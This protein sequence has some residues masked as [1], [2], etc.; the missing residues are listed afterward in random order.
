MNGGRLE[1]IA[2]DWLMMGRKMRAGKRRKF[3]NIDA[4][5]RFAIAIQVEREWP[6]IVQ[7]LGVDEGMTFLWFL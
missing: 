6:C 3:W 2:I 5:E 1:G 7:W 4:K